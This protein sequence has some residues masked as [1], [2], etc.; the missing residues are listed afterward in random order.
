[1]SLIVD[2]CYYVVQFPVCASPRSELKKGRYNT[3]RNIVN[4]SLEK[5]LGFEYR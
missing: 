2:R 5:V 4:Q 1:M 3:P